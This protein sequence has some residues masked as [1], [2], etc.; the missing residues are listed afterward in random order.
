MVPT[1]TARFDLVLSFSVMRSL[2]VFTIFISGCSVGGGGLVDPPSPKTFSRVTEQTLIELFQSAERTFASVDEG[3]N[4]STSRECSNGS[5]LEIN[6]ETIRL[7][8]TNSE[9]TEFGTSYFAYDNENRYAVVVF[10]TERG[11][12]QYSVADFVL[13]SNDILVFRLRPVGQDS[14]RV[15]TVHSVVNTPRII[16]VCESSKGPVFSAD[17]LTFNRLSSRVSFSFRGKQPN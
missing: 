3:T 13:A 5:Y 2:I 17:D 14:F 8:W 11:S 7:S 16:E 10:I 15:F 9:V 12:H 6:N 4:F 1:S